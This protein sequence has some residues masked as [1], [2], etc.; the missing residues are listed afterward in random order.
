MP[1][2]HVAVPLL[3]DV[4]TSIDALT[5]RRPTT[6]G[7]IEC[8]VLLPAADPGWAFEGDRNL[9]APDDEH[10][11]RDPLWTRSTGWP[12]TRWGRIHIDSILDETYTATISAVGLIPVSG[13]FH[14]MTVCSTST[15]RPGSGGTCCATGCP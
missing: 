7:G 6:I 5:L 14:G 15:R 2:Q 12:N 8:H 3:E 11:E 4:H 9:K 13:Q 1:K 10:E